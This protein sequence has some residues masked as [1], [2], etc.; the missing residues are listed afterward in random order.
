MTYYARVQRVDGRLRV[1]LSG[2]G[3]RYVD[4]DTIAELN[5]LLS[6]EIVA[7]DATGAATDASIYF[8]LPE[9]LQP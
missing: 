6:A 7:V 3:G 2:A 5:R 4:A 1:E 8:D 9:D